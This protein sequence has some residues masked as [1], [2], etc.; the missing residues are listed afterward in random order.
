[1]DGRGHT[2]E[3][4]CT[5]PYPVQLRGKFMKAPRALVLPLTAALTREVVIL[6]IVVFTHMVPEAQLT[7]NRNT[8][9]QYLDTRGI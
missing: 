8:R 6:S 7:V 3:H 2:V 9:P 4:Y 1:M 5:H